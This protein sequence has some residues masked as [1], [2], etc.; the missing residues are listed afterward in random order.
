MKVMTEKKVILFGSEYEVNVH[1]EQYDNGR[2]A[3]QLITVIGGQEIKPF[4]MLTVNMPDHDCPE[5]EIWLK[6]WAENEGWA[7]QF[8]VKNRIIEPFTTD[9]A[10]TGYV[11]VK[12]YKL[13]Q[14]FLQLMIGALARQQENMIDE[15]HDVIDTQIKKASLYGEFSRSES[16]APNHGWINDELTPISSTAS[17][18][19][20]DRSDS[21]T[22]GGGESGGAG[23]SGS[24]D[25]G[26]SS[27]DSSS[28]DSSSSDSSS[29]SSG[30]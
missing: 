7:Y 10:P 27:S 9:V 29:S 11:N 1:F 20:P 3:I 5:D 13:H 26:S 2:L 25:S 15:L 19:E 24:W 23:A 12:R 6:D 17:I 18:P 22:P 8:A 16:E 4:G 30:E 28:S 21:F 14:H